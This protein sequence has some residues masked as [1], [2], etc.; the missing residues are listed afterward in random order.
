MLS[1]AGRSSRSVDQLTFGL[2]IC[3]MEYWRIETGQAWGRDIL[4]TGFSQT[5]VVSIFPHSRIMILGYYSKSNR[6]VLNLGIGVLQSLGFWDWF[7]IRPSE[8]LVNDFRVLALET[9]ITTGLGISLQ[10]R[11]A[12]DRLCPKIFCR[13]NRYLQNAKT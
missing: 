9:F 6:T 5:L 4:A 12:K 3:L 2:S 8:K 7:P 11:L 1:T 10:H 13:L